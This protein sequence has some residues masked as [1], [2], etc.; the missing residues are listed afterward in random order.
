MSLSPIP[1]PKSRKPGRPPTDKVQ[2][3]VSVSPGHAD[4]IRD[5]SLHEGRKISDTVERM[6]AV[7]QGAPKH[8]LERLNKLRK[9]D[10]SDHD[11]A[12]LRE[13]QDRIA[14]LLF[15]EQ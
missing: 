11:K 10:L 8:L 14:F 1:A 4:A 15:A 2:F 6:V 5:F 9:G 12:A 3:N 7:Y 13:M